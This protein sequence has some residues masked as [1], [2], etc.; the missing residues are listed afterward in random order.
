MSDLR[1]IIGTCKTYGSVLS[2]WYKAADKFWPEG[3][4]TS[5]ICTDAD[6]Q[7]PNLP[8][9]RVIAQDS[10]WCARLI[11]CLEACEDEFITLVLDDYIL[12][13]P[14]DHNTLLELRD[15]MQKEGDIG[16]IYL[17]DIGLKSVNAERSGLFEIARGPFSINSCPGLW[18]RE[19]LLETLKPFQDPWAWEAFAF[20]TPAAKQHKITCWGPSLYNYSFKT[21]GLI[22]RGAISRAAF[23]RIE[24]ETVLGAKL[25]WFP[26]FSLEAE[27]PSAKRSLS[28]KL[29]FLRAGWRV[30]TATAV[31]F[32]WFG[33]QAK[34]GRRGS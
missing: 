20:G 27:G 12:D 30:S 25:S 21:G 23:K 11:A 28:W 9:E 15:R 14:L 18:R 22:Y 17:T 34:L 33:V 5:T 10:G 3:A 32:I 7:L 16:V 4:A 8:K 29:K 6:P 24:P 13:A 26:D 31:K 1:I 19:F 2:V